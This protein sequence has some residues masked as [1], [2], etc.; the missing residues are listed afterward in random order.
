MKQA[1]LTLTI[2]ARRK[3]NQ[4]S[5][6]DVYD[7]QEP[8]VLLL[9][10]LL[11]KN[12]YRKDAVLIGPPRNRIS[13]VIFYVTCSPYKSKLSFQYGFKVFLIT[14][15]VLVCSPPRVATAKGSGKPIFNNQHKRATKRRA[16]YGRH[17]ACRAH[18]RQLLES[19]QHLH[20]EVVSSG[21]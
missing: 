11:V 20:M 14:L 8:L 9:E 15:V 6:T 12:L 17:H 5:H 13:M 21:G 3:I 1:Q 16:T 2:L 4:I 7:T 10:L 18:L 19:Y